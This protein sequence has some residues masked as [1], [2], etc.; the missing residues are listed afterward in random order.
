MRASLGVLLVVLLAVGFFA[1]PGLF[2]A[3]NP[4]YWIALNENEAP[5]NA[6]RNKI[7][8][9]EIEIAKIDAQIKEG[10]K[11]LIEIAATATQE[12][13][14]RSEPEAKAL[15]SDALARAGKISSNGT[16]LIGER[17]KI[18]TSLDALRK[19]ES[20]IRVNIDK[21]VEQSKIIYLVTR[22]LSLGAVGAIMSIL[23]QSLR[24]QPPQLAG[25]LSASQVAGPVA[26]GAV[27][28]VVVVGLFFTGFIS[29][30]SGSG[31]GAKDVD[32]WKITILCL[33]A[34]AFADRLFQSA[35]S[36]LTNYLAP[37]DADG[38]AAHRTPKPR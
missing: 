36:R 22:A 13:A 17:K 31:D 14:G 10:D 26:L 3:L 6:I 11:Q 4:D 7:S 29:I 38:K 23:A 20:D 2:K 37:D 16:L 18:E 33:L 28:S 21:S 34:G 30:F 35:S 9:A 1:T 19:Q 27:V 5:R 8:D 15:M 32:F 24:V 12:A 25:Q